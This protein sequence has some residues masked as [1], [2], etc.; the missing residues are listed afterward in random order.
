MNVP[1]II[2]GNY[3]YAVLGLP[4]LFIFT[5]CSFYNLTKQN[6]SN[7]QKITSNMEHFLWCVI[8]IIKYR[9]TGLNHVQSGLR[10]TYLISSRLYILTNYNHV[11]TH[12]QFL[13]PPL[14]G[15]DF[16]LVFTNWVYFTCVLEDTTWEL[17]VCSIFIS[18]H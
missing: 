10:D 15:F 1:Y 2:S 6:I 17:L 12:F 18:S 11:L 14:Q 4:S 9:V 16:N 5:Y 13:A 7:Y 3:L 8:H